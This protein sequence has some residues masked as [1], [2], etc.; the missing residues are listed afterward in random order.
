MDLGKKKKLGKK[1]MALENSTNLE[2]EVQQKWLQTGN[3]ITIDTAYEEY[4]AYFD[5]FVFH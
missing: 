5:I 3:D 4:I 1:I 2:L